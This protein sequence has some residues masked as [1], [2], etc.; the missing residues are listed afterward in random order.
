MNWVF[1]VTWS[2]LVPAPCDH[3]IT[4]EFER[5]SMIGCTLAHFAYEPKKKFFDSRE[6]A[7]VFLDKAKNA[8]GV[9]GASI[10]SVES[11]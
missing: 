11:K 5:Q 4:D 2:I 1:F 10:D 3:K 6:S 7:V 9:Y 8:S